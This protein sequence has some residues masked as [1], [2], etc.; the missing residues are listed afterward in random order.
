[1]RHRKSGR[2][3]GRNSSSRKA[4]FRNMVTSLMLHGQIRTTEPKAKELRSFADKVISLGKGAPSLEGLEA[5]E[6]A[7]AKA[8]R[9]HLIRRARLLIN[10]DEALDKVF[11]E[12]AERFANRPGGYTRV[13]KAGIRGGDNASMAIVQLVEGPSAE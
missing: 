6:L 9:V 1:M 8:R 11:G 13:V 5:G 2:K 4:M 7:A 3:F 10:N 12:Y